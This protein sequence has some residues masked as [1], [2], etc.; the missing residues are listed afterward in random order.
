MNIKELLVEALSMRAYA[1]PEEYMIRDGV[2][3]AIQILNQFKLDLAQPSSLNVK[4]D[5]VAAIYW[6]RDESGEFFMVPNNQWN[7]G[8]KLTKAQLAKEIMQ[9]GRKPATQSDS[10]F[11]S[12]RKGM[13]AEYL[14]Q[15]ALLEKSSPQ[16]GFY[17]GDIMFS[18]PPV[19]NSDGVYEFT[20][21]KVTYYANPTGEVGRAIANGAELFI[22]IHGL[23]QE[24]G[25]DPT[26][27]LQ[28]VSH[29]DLTKLNQRNNK[30]Y[31]LSE[32]PT[33]SAISVDVGFIDRAISKLKQSQSRIDNFMSYTAPRFS[34]FRNILRDYTN[35]QAK[36]NHSL[37]FDSYLEL[38]KLSDSQ[39][40][41]AKEYVDANQEDFKLF[42]QATS[43]VIDTKN[44]VLAHLH[45]TH[46]ESMSDRLGLSA[47]THGTQGGEGYARITPDGEGIKYIN[48]AFRSAPVNARFAESAESL[49]KVAIQFGRY[50]PP[51]HGHRAAWKQ[52][53]QYPKW[54]VGTNP[55]TQGEKDPLPFE[56]KIE[57]MKTVW[58]EV[59]NHLVVETSW[60]TLASKVYREN[61]GVVLYCLTDEEWVTKTLLAYNGKEGAHGYY[62]FSDIQQ[63]PTPRISS[64]TRLRQAIANN[65]PK[66][67]YDAAGV[68]PGTQIN[69]QGYF[70]IVAKYL[71]PYLDK[72][73]INKEAVNMKGKQTNNDPVAKN[74][75][76]FNKAATHTDKKKDAKRGYIKHK[77]PVEES[78]QPTIQIG[79]LI[80]T[81]RT[82]FE[83]VVVGFKRIN[84]IDYVIFK[85]PHNGKHYKA[86]PDN[87]QVE[88]VDETTTSG[89]M[90][91]VASPIGG[92][93]RRP[94]PSVYGS[95]K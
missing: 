57:A 21:N 51:H 86:T 53:S 1:H 5:G 55:S 44:Q 61:P 50:N 26:S 76:K 58:P 42:D 39:K 64:A 7:K 92:L 20:P 87:V 91:T 66:D 65:S 89:G 82:Q 49:A 14:R 16:Q 60:L 12:I 77:T 83:G 67:F 52:A 28:P 75:N 25:T 62:N 36:H 74:M 37:N 27:D 70:E 79:D 45:S 80:R 29:A 30:V 32:R 84:S 85:S 38:A 71:Q 17:W 2:N 3:R 10:E 41:L 6:G 48:P 8:Q 22:A 15:W 40:L 35:Q 9:T 63:D 73:K 78:A 47:S 31:L 18:S 59:S 19:L 33:D 23:V 11:A 24:F 13:S 94:N 56:I 68:D 93:R 81:R 69:G 88:S 46:Q 95:K 72:K 54:Y 43:L 34:A 4:W 90:A